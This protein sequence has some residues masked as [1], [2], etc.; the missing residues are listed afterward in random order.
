MNLLSWRLEY[1]PIMEI[2]MVKQNSFHSFAVSYAEG[3]PHST[4]SSAVESFLHRTPK[5]R[6]RRSCHAVTD[7]NF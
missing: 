2:E 4:V 7:S 5:V 6:Y 1:V 3:S